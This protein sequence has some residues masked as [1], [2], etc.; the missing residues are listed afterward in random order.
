MAKDKKDENKAAPSANNGPE[1]VFGHNSP[2]T[3]STTSG[4]KGCSC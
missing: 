2:P 3:S 4:G 1:V